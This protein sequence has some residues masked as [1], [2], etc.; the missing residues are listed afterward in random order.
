V[1]LSPEALR[2]LL[3]SGDVAVARRLLVDAFAAGRSLDE[4]GD[5]VV[6]PAMAQ[7]GTLWARGEIDVYHEHV[8]TQR[9]WSILVEVRGLLPEP[10]EQAPLAVGGAPEGDGYVLPSLVVELTLLD[11]GWRVLNLGPETPMSTLAGAV[12]EHRPRLVWL[13][14]T[15]RRPSPAFL[16]EY[17]QLLA[18]AREGR[19]GIIVG[20]Q[21]VTPE[22]Q[23]HLV[24]AAFGTRLAHLREFTRTL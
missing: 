15:T 19:A 9:L 13:S 12:R 1:S 24:A 7:V 5:A 20:G 2:D 10:G 8:A 16:D 22:L 6:G 3:L 21:A 4:I 17:P 18:A 23:D 11:L 14:I